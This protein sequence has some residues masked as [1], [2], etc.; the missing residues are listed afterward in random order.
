MVTLA[1][2]LATQPV[3]TLRVLSPFG[4][5]WERMILLCMQTLEGTPHDVLGAVVVLAVL[6]AAGHARAQPPD[7][8][9]GGQCVRRQGRAG[10]RRRSNVLGD[11]RNRV[12]NYRNMYI[13]DGSMLGANLGVNA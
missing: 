4:F 6:E 8:H 7:L 10:R 11:R 5:A 13:C 1:R 9:S 3:R 2:L 12:F